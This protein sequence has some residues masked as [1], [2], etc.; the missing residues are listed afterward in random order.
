MELAIRPRLGIGL[1]IEFNEDICYRAEN[2]DDDEGEY[3]LSYVGTLIKL[4]FCT[5]YIGEFY[6]VVYE[7]DKA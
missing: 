7:E 1:D 2:E 4:P 6:E 5:I 3:L